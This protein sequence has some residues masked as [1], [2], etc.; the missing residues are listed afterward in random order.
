GGEPIAQGQQVRRAGAEGADFVGDRLAGADARTG[1]DA[2]LM[3]VEPGTLHVNDV[4]SHLHGEMAA[5]WSPRQRSLEGARSGLS[6]VAAVRGARGAPGPTTIR[7]LRTNAGP[8]SVPTPRADFTAF[9]A[10]R[11]RSAGGQLQ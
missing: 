1:D 8:T 7:A 6:P 11:V 5:A 9:H 2:L 4:H 3:H 10:T